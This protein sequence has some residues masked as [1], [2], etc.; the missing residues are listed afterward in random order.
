MPI[1]ASQ[2]FLTLLTMAAIYVALRLGATGIALLGLVV[3]IFQY[4]VGELLVSQRRSEELQRLATTDDLTG[5]AN[6]ELFGSGLQAAI[7]G[8]GP[9]RG[10]FGV[11]RAL[12][13][14]RLQHGLFLARLPQPS[15]DR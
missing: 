13:G 14:R 12:L 10:S 5:L 4:L 11:L 15:A 7:A 2:L 9:L 6:R 3:V 1:L 8:C